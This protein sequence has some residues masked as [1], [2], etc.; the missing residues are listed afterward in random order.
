[1][2]F[3]HKQYFTKTGARRR[4]EAGDGRKLRLDFPERIAYNN[5]CLLSATVCSGIEVVIT[6]TTGNRIGFV[7]A[8]AR[9]PLILLDSRIFLRPARRGFLRFFYALPQVRQNPGKRQLNTQ[10]YRSGHNEHDWKSCDRQ[11]RSEGSNPSH[12][13]KIK[14][15]FAYFGKFPLDFA[16][17]EGISSTPVFRQPILG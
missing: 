6:S 8:D 1:M 17:F 15:E 9:Q 11:K 5:R 3:F 2:F 14:R 13:A 10:W 12:C 7:S 16:T 4:A